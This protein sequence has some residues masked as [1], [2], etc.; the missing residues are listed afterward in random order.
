MYAFTCELDFSFAGKAIW[1]A[2]CVRVF[3]R[4]AVMNEV[5]VWNQLRLDFAAGDCRRSVEER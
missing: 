4:D 3:G 5:T 1:E 2:L